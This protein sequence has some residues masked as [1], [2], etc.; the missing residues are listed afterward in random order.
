MQCGGR[1]QTRP[2][3]S[4]LANGRPRAGLLSSPGIALLPWQ[5]LAME[6]T[7]AWYPCPA[8]P[9]VV[10]PAIWSIITAAFRFLLRH[11]GGWQPPPSDLGG[12]PL[13][14]PQRRRPCPRRA[15][16]APSASLTQLPPSQWC[17]AGYV[18]EMMACIFLGY[19]I[20]YSS[21]FGRFLLLQARLRAGAACRLP[22]RCRRRCCQGP[23]ASRAKPAPAG[24]EAPSAALQRPC[25]QPP[26]SMPPFGTAT[27]RSWTALAQWL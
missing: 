24:L 14:P 2:R 25:S 16:C 12:V 11:C 4:T 23:T 26:H 18:P 7:S 3:I 8:L 21:M 15:R 9:Q 13:P 22:C 19:P 5:T 6:N 27:P 1:G 17:L 20:L 10:H